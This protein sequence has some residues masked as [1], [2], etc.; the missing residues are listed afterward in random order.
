[1]N[2]INLKKNPTEATGKLGVT[3]NS[4]SSYIRV[5]TVYFLLF[6]TT[7]NTISAFLLALKGWNL[8]CT[9]VQQDTHSSPDEF[10]RNI[11]ETD[12]HAPDD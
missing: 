2:K 11:R 5:N 12:R 10:V 3:L 1:M 6:A 9:A 7:H 8:N 4:R